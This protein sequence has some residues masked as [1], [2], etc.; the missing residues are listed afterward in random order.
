MSDYL[1]LKSHPKYDYSEK[2]STHV[3]LACM[4][5][6]ESLLHFHSCICMT[7][8]LTLVKRFYCCLRFFFFIAVKKYHDHATF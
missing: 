4:I 7:F 2:H 5:P 8:H 3:L 6:T 1:G